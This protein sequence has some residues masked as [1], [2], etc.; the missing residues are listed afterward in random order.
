MSGRAPWPEDLLWQL[1]KGHSA[2][3]RKQRGPNGAKGTHRF[4]TA[5]MSCTN[6]YTR[7]DC[8]F[9]KPH[10][11]AVVRDRTIVVLRRGKGHCLSKPSTLLTSQEPKKALPRRVARKIRRLRSAAKRVTEETDE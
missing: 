1:S 5:Q 8:G 6:K 9:V 10:Q 11:N 7:A 2:F 4:S 3:L